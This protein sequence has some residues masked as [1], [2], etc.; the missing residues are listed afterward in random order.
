M[1]AQPVTNRDFRKV[2]NATGCA[3]F[4]EI[5]PKSDDDP[6]ALHM[7]KR[8]PRSCSRRPSMPSI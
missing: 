4:A 1:D 2:V 7:I 6:G 5:K 8:R 3:T